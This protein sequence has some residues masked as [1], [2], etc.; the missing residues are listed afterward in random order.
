MFLLLENHLHLER[1]LYLSLRS[2]WLNLREDVALEQGQT[3]L[4]I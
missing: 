1:A 2:T 3:V 4:E